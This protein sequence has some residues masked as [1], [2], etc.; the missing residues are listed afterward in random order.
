[1]CYDGLTEHALELRGYEA[2]AERFGEHADPIV[3]ASVAWT[4]YNRA[5]TLSSLSRLSEAVSSYDLAIELGRKSR[6][7]KDVDAKELVAKSM[8]NRANTLVQMDK[9]AEAELAYLEVIEAF[10]NSDALGLQEQVA[11]SRASLATLY[12]KLDETKKALAE[13]SL[14]SARRS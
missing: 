5:I 11:R 14:L 7:D 10:G 2:L 1:M 9:S 13:G 8:Y 4:Y 3:G 12:F 6:D